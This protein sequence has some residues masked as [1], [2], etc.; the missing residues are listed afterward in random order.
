MPQ[1]SQPFSGD[2]FSDA[3]GSGHI[4][5]ASSLWSGAPV[6]P[7][8]WASSAPNVGRNSS[9]SGF[10][11]PGSILDRRHARSGRSTVAA[12][13]QNDYTDVMPVAILPTSVDH[14]H[15][16]RDGRRCLVRDRSGGLQMFDLRGGSGGGSGDD[17]WGQARGS[18]GIAS[19]CGIRPPCGALVK[20]F[21]PPA[22]RRW[23]GTPGKFALDPGETVVASPI[24]PATRGRSGR[25]RRGGSNTPHVPSTVASAWDPFA[26]HSSDSDEMPLLTTHYGGDS[27]DDRG[28]AAGGSGRRRPRG[29]G[30]NFFFPREDSEESG[31]DRLRISSVS[32]GDV[33]SDVVTPF[34]KLS[35]ARGTLGVRGATGVV[36]QSGFCHGDVVFRGI[37][38]CPRRDARVLVEAAL[39]PEE[40][41]EKQ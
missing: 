11:L 30:A 35:L 39:W 16:L 27:D 31:W 25:S 23:A 38:T 32:S 20:V 9:R 12:I 3:A 28:G 4:N 5:S 13:G 36:G 2:H 37:A 24:P 6:G 40:E 26:G 17:G 18:S 34:K 22:P 7:G 19:K 15:V 29:A 33:V 1:A 21:V 10:S 8:G 14:M 41:E